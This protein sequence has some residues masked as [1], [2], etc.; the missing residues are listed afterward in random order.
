MSDIVESDQPEKI[1]APKVGRPKKSEY[2]VRPGGANSTEPCEACNGTGHQGGGPS[3]WVVDRI[4]KDC[5]T[6]SW[7][8]ATE[9]EAKAYASNA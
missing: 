3:K 1:A 7:S 5:V 9:D 8:F 2:V 6:E 4:E